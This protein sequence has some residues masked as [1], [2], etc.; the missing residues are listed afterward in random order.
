MDRV[1]APNHV[2]FQARLKD[3]RRI[4]QVVRT[5]AEFHGK[6]LYD[7]IL[8]HT[9]TE[10]DYG[11]VRLLVRLP[12]GVDVAVVAELERVLSAEACPLSARG[13]TN[14][15]WTSSSVGGESSAP[16]RVKLRA[17]PISDLVW[18]VHIV[19][20]SADMCRRLRVGQIPPLFGVTG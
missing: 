2:F 10:S 16:R 6:E 8:Y 19:P 14:L 20:D 18:V 11:Q 15:R 13:C 4:R 17:V 9:G 5:S 7:H 3:G 12:G 1:A